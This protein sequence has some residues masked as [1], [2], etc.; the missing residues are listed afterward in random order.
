MSVRLERQ[1]FVN[2]AFR[3]SDTVKAFAGR[4][5]ELFY[6]VMLMGYECP[7]CSGNLSMTGESRCRCSGCGH[8]L[9]PTTTFQRCPG[10]GGRVVLHVCRYRCRRCGDDVPSRFVFDGK[11][12]DAEYFRAKMAESRQ[13]RTQRRQ[14]AARRTIENRSAALEP[15]EL[16][17]SSVPG[18]LDALNG[19]TG[20]IETL[21]WRPQTGGFDLSRYQK[22]LQAYIGPEEQPF[23]DLPALEKDRRLD[24]I[25]RF[26]TIIFMAHFGLIDIAQEEQTILVKQHETD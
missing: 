19:L 10:C 7:R 17:L 21:A 18:L 22:H 11:L 13:R 15:Q 4:A 2:L 3:L 26:V 1:E 12:F 5:K 20:G 24:R 6:A 9:D 8:V 14:Q 25:W 16:D 23:D